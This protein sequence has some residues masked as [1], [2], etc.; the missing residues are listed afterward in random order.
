VAHHPVS[1]AAELAQNTYEIVVVDGP[2]MCCS[3]CGVHYPGPDMVPM[4]RSVGEVGWE[5]LALAGPGMAQN[6]VFQGHMQHAAELG[7]IAQMVWQ[8]LWRAVSQ[9]LCP[10]TCA[11]PACS[12]VPEEWYLLAAGLAWEG[13][14]WAPDDGMPLRIG[15]CRQHS[16]ELCE[17]LRRTSHRSAWMEL[18]HHRLAFI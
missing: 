8:Q 15:L 6:V 18:P 7:Q 5:L 13:W 11:L 10:W 12:C 4:I 1:D 9:R 16:V 17:K 2:R 14:L 3:A